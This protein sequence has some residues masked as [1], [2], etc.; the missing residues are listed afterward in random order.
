VVNRKDSEEDDGVVGF[1]SEALTQKG[2]LGQGGGNEVAVTSR[3]Q[4]G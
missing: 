4:G 1:E 2:R 3:V